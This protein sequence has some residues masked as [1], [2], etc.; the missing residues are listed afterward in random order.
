MHPFYCCLR[1]A[2]EDQGYSIHTHFTKKGCRSIQDQKKRWPPPK[3]SSSDGAGASQGVGANTVVGK[4]QLFSSCIFT[5]FSLS[6]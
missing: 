6:S 4:E 2:A 5:G 1:A 3:M